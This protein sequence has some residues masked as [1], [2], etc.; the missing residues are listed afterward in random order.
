MMGE[1]GQ[2][3]AFRQLLETQVNTATA[4]ALFGTFEDTRIIVEEA[5][6]R[7]LGGGDVET[8]LADAKAQADARLREY[9]ANF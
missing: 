7:V 3:A 9:N 5:V 2:T 6:Q 4:G 1:A 8:A